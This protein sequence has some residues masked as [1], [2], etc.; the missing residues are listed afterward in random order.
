MNGQQQQPWGWCALWAVALVALAVGAVWGLGQLEAS[1]AD[2]ARAEAAVEAA[3]WRGRVELE[4]AR[5]DRDREANLHREYMFQSWT[6]A[7]GRGQDPVP[8]AL[9]AM[10]GA[11]AAWVVIRWVERAGLP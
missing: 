6:V 2:R 8:V 4:Q 3:E 10:A 1:R 11:V 5:L 9:A 7:L